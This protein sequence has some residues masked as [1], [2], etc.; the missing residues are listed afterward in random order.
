NPDP[1]PGTN[2]WHAQ[3]GYSGGTYSNCADSSQKGVASVNAYL[4]KLNV[5]PNC[6]KGHYYLLNNYNPGYVGN[7]DVATKSQGPF[8]IPPSS[9]PTIADVLIAGKVS[10]AYYGESWNAYVND[11]S[12]YAE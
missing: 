4:S 8:T 11:P 7:G 1:G 2:T 5:S 10:W 9:V 6:Q 3:D 12:Y